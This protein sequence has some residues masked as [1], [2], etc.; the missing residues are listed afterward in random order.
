MPQGG[1]DKKETMEHTIIREINEELGN[2]FTASLRVNSLVG[3]NQINFPNH[4]K[5]SRQLRTDAGEDIFMEGKKYF[6]IAIDTDNYDINIEQ[7]EFDDYKWLNYENAIQ[8]S[9]TI[10]QK[11]K[12]RITLDAIN[13]LHNLGLL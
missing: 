8:L 10:Y 4:H 11:G 1:I 12:Q 2:E 5:N 13:K 6:F 3:D 9:K 7:T